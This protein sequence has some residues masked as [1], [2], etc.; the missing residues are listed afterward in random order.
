MPFKGISQ[1]KKNERPKINETCKIIKTIKGLLKLS[2]EQ[3]EVKR[4]DLSAAYE[5]WYN[6]NGLITENY[7]AL[8]FLSSLLN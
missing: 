7:S 2:L 6:L 5:R 3:Q 8:A 4:T 1:K